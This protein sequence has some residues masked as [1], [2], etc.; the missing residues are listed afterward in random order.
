MR[1]QIIVLVL[2]I[3]IVACASLL[4]AGVGGI[5]WS[6][7]VKYKEDSTGETS[8]SIIVTRDGKTTTVSL[9]DAIIPTNLKE[10]L[11]DAALASK[12]VSV[13]YEW[14]DDKKYIVEVIVDGSK[15]MEEDDLT[16]FLFE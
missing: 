10:L 16:P 12:Y 3:T 11:K 9:D 14:K 7:Y 1:K 6:G 5:G 4:Y 15:K 8:I 13:C 2:T